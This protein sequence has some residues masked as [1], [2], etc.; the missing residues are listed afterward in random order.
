MPKQDSLHQLI[1]M[2]TTTEKRS[3][4]TTAN[5][6]AKTSSS[7]IEIFDILCKQKEYDEVKLI[8]S[9][10]DSN[11]LKNLNQNKK[12][13]KDLILKSLR[14]NIE[15]TAIDQVNELLKEREIFRSKNLF[16]EEWK[17]IQKA[18]QISIDYELFD[19]NLRILDIELKY[20]IERNFD[21]AE[22]YMDIYKEEKKAL[23]ENIKIFNELMILKNKVFIVLRKYKTL[24]DD[25][26]K[27]EIYVEINS[28]NEDE[29]LRKNIKSILIFYYTI[30]ANFST[31]QADKKAAMKYRK[32]ILDIGKSHSKF[33]TH[34][35]QLINYFN[36]IGSVFA[37]QDF[38][39]MKI[40]LN[41][42][43]QIQIKTKN[44]EGE[45]FQNYALYNT[46]YFLNSGKIE[47]AKNLDS[48]IRAG[49]KKHQKKINAS[50]LLTLCY[51][52]SLIYFFN[53]EFELALD[54]IE[55]IEEIKLNVRRD[56]YHFSQIL[57]IMCHF[58]LKNYIL[59]ESLVRSTKR[60]NKHTAFQN[61]VLSKIL[62]SAKQSK[63]NLSDLKKIDI[64]IK[65]IKQNKTRETALGIYQLW[66]SSYLRPNT[67][68][69]LYVESI[70]L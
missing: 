56:L 21:K 34:A 3:F 20:L 41:E 47:E 65:K 2:L 6:N 9:L 16:K 11:S 66:I 32:K 58:D 55:K 44:N 62:S 46:L 57:K 36:Y 68:K 43:K 52:Y 28:F 4:K 13:V 39:L 40:V 50:S 22:L 33:T 7:S 23:L 35:S 53:E 30:L 60:V 27:D 59:I 42:V 37:M 1:L 17:K 45:F 10:K 69:E 51:N 5:K 67:L 26:I 61:L 31:I 38:D 15:N 8:K 29:L 48:E 12:Y 54:W 63:A 70:S 64:E 19:M 49:I 24:A 14:S 18:K 25:K